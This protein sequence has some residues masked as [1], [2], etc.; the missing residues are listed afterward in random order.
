MR[1]EKILV[2]AI[3]EY[4]LNIRVLCWA[5]VGDLNKSKKDNPR[6]PYTIPNTYIDA[7]TLHLVFVC[8]MIE[9]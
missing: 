3:P 1:V 2:P 6:N 7:I 5:K 4:K 8:D 9:K